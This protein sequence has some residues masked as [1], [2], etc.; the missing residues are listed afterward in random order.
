MTSAVSAR[1][2]ALLMLLLAW[3]ASAHDPSAWGGLF[4]S[5]DFGETWFPSDA[6]LFIGGALAIA[7]HPDD[8][9]HLLYGT[10]TRLLRS[11]NGGR[12]WVTE[13]PSVMAGA[14]FAVAFDADG[15]G[16]LASTGARIFRTDD[17]AAWHDVMAP[18]GA[19]PARGFASGTRKERVYLAGAHGLFVS[20]DRG[21][22]WTRTGDGIL[23]ESTVR[24]LFVVPGPPDR[25][26]AVIS[27]RLWTGGQDSSWR[28]VPGLPDGKVET[29]ARGATPHRLWA[30]AADRVFVSDDLGESWKPHGRPLADPGTTVRGIAVSPDSRT[31]VLSTH[32]GAWRSRDAGESWYQVESNLPV[33]LEAGLLVPDPHE[34]STM[35]AGF[36]LKPYGEMYRLA[37]Q[38]GSTIAS[39][40]PF[41]LAGAGA[42]LVLL[43]VVG[44]LTVRWLVHARG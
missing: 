6:G 19:A 21:R 28:A 37:E 23:P 43:I 32:R 29:L 24:S 1:A 27:G 20:D 4:R 33:H 25:V 7:I 35:Y 31:I 15:A 22:T 5:R 17:Q 11:R 44:S 39:L 26:F 40:D 12:D 8:P 13:A 30:F 36:S 14:V 3:P 41:S 16:A 42:F 34:P 9:N 38:G 10:D 2:L 18:G